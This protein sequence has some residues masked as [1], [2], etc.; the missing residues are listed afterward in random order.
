MMTRPLHNLDLILTLL[1]PRLLRHVEFVIGRDDRVIVAKT[2]VE[3]DMLLRTNPVSIA[4]IDPSSDGAGKT[5]EFERVRANYPSLPIV[6]YVPLTAAAFRAVA[7]LSRLGLDHVILYCHDDSADRMLA[8]IDKARS[9]PLTIRFIK[10]LRPRLDRLPISIVKA[11][12]EMLAEPHR[13]PSA[14]DI[15]LSA[16]VSVVRLYRSF[17]HANLGPPRRMVMAAKLLRAYSHL[18]DPGQSVGGVS[19]KLAY[20][21]P[22]VLAEHMNE[23]FGLTPSRVK[24]YLTE[25]QAVARLLAWIVPD[26]TN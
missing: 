6:A 22:R 20:R 21:N 25:D 12:E 15:A 8:T 9:N 24:D 14:Q 2:W 13:Y 23:V 11:V 18:R 10:V 5:T 16:N 3:L 4:V 17:H 7:Q 26:E 19:T 1:P